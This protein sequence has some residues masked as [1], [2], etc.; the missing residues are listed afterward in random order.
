MYFQDQAK[1]K[2]L[3][4]TIRNL[5]KFLVGARFHPAYDPFNV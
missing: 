5:G 4:K 1:G 2:R 3:K